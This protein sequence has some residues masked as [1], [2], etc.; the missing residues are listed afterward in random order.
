MIFV[1]LEG[2]SR[3]SGAA[4]TQSDLHRVE[5]NKETVRRLV[6]AHN[7]QDAAAAAACF[8]PGGTN[9]GRVAGPQGMER[10]Y[11]ELYVAFPDYHWEIQLLL[12]EGDWVAAHVVMTGTHLGQP[13]MPVLGGLIR[14]HPPTGKRVSVVNIHVYRMRDGLIVEHSAA[15]DDLGMMQQLGLARAIEKPADDI[16]R[17]A[18]PVS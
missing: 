15:R 8:A 2:F 12:G 17:P 14:S 9:H 10:L 13:N 4:M 6:A 5:V 7:R 1:Y 16:S 18:R 11:R 3:H